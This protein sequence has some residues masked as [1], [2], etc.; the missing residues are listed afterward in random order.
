MSSFWH[1]IQA[2]LGAIFLLAGLLKVGEMSDFI[3]TV[4][5]FSVVPA[6]L[7]PTIAGI[8]A[9][10]EVICGGAL[11]CGIRQRSA[12]HVL[13]FLCLLFSIAI[14]INLFRGNTIPCGCFGTLI[15]ER[16]SGGV[17]VRDLLFAATLFRLG[18]QTGI[19]AEVCISSGIFADLWPALG[20]VISFLYVHVS[21]FTT[22]TPMRTP[23]ENQQPTTTEHIKPMP[24]F[25]R[26]ANVFAAPGELFENVRLTAPT[27]SNWIIP[28]I[29]MIIVAVAMSQLVISNPSLRDQMGALIKKS[30][31]ESV[32]SGRMTQEQADQAYE[33]FASPSS[34]MAMVIR[35]VATIAGI[36]IV[37]FVVA[38]AYWL[39]GK[40][41]MKAT[42]PY[43]KV[44]EIIGLTFLIG[45]LE[46]LIT[47][48]MMFLM[49]SLYASPSLGL[50]VLKDF[51]IQ[52][53]LHV[54][55]A[56]VNVFTLWS[57]AVTSVGLSKL[58]QR[59]FAKVA[60]LVFALWIVW[61][62]VS[63]LT[64]IRFG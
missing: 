4:E 51:D 43:M 29:L 26:V 15:E 2:L 30:M 11:L 12:A 10:V 58:F 45:A 61:C 16:I 63:I 64:G 9:G 38:L 55:L 6:P 18:R 49:D 28:L 54:A 56:K 3:R 14:G 35:L 42:A 40:W 23:M 24:L 36:P 25:E 41:G 33:Q 31:E 48:I 22:P 62:V 47:T 34:T 60:V 21:S 32:Q 19:R 46:S 59:D 17:L 27:A 1:L 13:A 57:L 7:A 53:K 5:A 8:V 50:A 52:N 44:V 37:L 39:L 20:R